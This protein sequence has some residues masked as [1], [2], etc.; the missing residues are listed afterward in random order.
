[1]VIKIY[2]RAIK[3]CTYYKVS[4]RFVTKLVYIK[5]MSKS[6]PFIVKYNFACF[7]LFTPVGFFVRLTY[8]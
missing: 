5:M 3:H 4:F 7:V 1:M 6:R 2:S 8:N